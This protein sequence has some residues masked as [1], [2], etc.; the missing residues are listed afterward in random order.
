MATEE[1]SDWLARVEWETVAQL[2]TSVAVLIALIALIWQV[3]VNRHEQQY[4]RSSFRLRSA[5]EAFDEADNLLKDLNND[6]IAWISAARAVERGLRLAGGITEQDHRDFLEVHR[7]RYRRRF[8]RYLGHD[9][10]SM[11]ASFFYGA[12]RK[13][14]LK[15]AAEESTRRYDGRPVLL[16]IA[17]ISLKILHDFAEFPEGYEDPISTSTRFPDEF[18]KSATKS[19]M[20]PGLTEYLKHARRYRSING[21]LVEIGKEE[22]PPKSL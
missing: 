22:A 17:E 5:L 1:A 15:R 10:P 21:Q 14:D 7:D 4:Q 11:T 2:S 20:W 13:L 9:D 19:V 12:A 8:G 18:I 3:R 6:R 16:N